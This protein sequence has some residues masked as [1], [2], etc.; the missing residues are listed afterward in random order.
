MCVYGFP[1][2]GRHAPELLL[3]V[4]QEVPEV[5]VEQ[6][7][8]L[9]HLITPTTTNNLTTQYILHA[10]SVPGLYSTTGMWRKRHRHTAL[11]STHHD[12]AVV[13]V[14]DAEDEGRDAVP[15]AGANEVVNGL[16]VFGALVVVADEEVNGV[17]LQ[18]A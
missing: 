5:N 10:R 9:G 8:V 16:V 12:V 18:G 4:A 3:K 15:G 11:H 2:C 14:A 6:V 7:P 13:T 1:C 17:L